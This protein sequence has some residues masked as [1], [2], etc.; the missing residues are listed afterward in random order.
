MQCSIEF[1]TTLSKICEATPW[2][3][4]LF[5]SQVFNDLLWCARPCWILDLLTEEALVMI[6]RSKMLSSV[7]ERKIKKKNDYN[8]EQYILQQTYEQFMEGNGSKEEQKLTFQVAQSICEHIRTY[9]YV[10]IYVLGVRIRIY[11]T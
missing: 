11:I 7:M 9:T 2:L 3:Y 4:I 6:L 8:P 10:H 5:Y 1:L